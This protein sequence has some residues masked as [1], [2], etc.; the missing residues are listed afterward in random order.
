M[1]YFK[2]TSET[3]VN[4]LGITLF[5]LELTVDCKWGCHTPLLFLGVK[6]LQNGRKIRDW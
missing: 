4:A 6:N 2:L 5:R 1:K 3:K